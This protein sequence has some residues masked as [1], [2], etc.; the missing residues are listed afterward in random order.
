MPALDFPARYRP[1][2]LELGTRLLESRKPKTPLESLAR[3]LLVAFHDICITT[4]RDSILVEL[5][6]DRLDPAE[7]V[8]DA[9]ALADD[10]AR[11]ASLVA[12]LTKHDIDGGGPRGAR[13]G[14]LADCLIAALGLTLIDDADRA[15]SL[16][17]A[18]RAAIVAAITT[19]TEA[20]LAIPALRDKVI[21]DARKRCEQHHLGAFDKI[22]AQLDE[23]GMRIDK[24]PKVP[25]D[26][27]QAVQRHLVDSRNAIM[28]RIA[29]IAFDQAKAII[30]R[31]SAEAAARID[32]PVTHTLTPRDVAIRRACD[33]RLPKRAPVVADNLLTTLT[34]VAQLTW[35]AAEQK[36]R[37][38][39]ASATFAVGDLVEHPKFGRGAVVGVATQRVDIEFPG[40]KM[41]LVHRKS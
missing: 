20:E 14:Q 11:H 36:V 7:V 3:D 15:L 38:Y 1:L 8:A 13:S 41:T 24:Q 19:V 26:A 28:T 16:D 9:A 2:L 12:E 21:A 37:P 32:Q 40:G 33:P 29:N 35:R 39:A 17:G 4:A 22:A 10:V 25:L 31:A 6:G 5:A 27:S 30:T 23:R 34:E 18:T